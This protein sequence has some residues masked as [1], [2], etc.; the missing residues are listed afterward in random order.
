MQE[1]IS[2]DNSDGAD[3]LL[4][5]VALVVTTSNIT[6]YLDAKVQVH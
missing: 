3:G 5:N 1:S 4:H 6:F 2:A